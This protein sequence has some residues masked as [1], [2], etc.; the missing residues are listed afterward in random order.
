MTASTASST[1]SSAVPSSVSADIAMLGPVQIDV[2]LSSS[3]FNGCGKGH[4]TNE[5]DLIIDSKYNK[6]KLISNKF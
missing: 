1:E 6:I 4:Q 5:C 2:D 3:F